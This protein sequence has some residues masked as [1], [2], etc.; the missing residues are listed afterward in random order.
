MASGVI[1]II[2]QNFA[3]AVADAMLQARKQ[4]SSNGEG[5]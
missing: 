3:Y 1:Y 5:V 4:S 2:P